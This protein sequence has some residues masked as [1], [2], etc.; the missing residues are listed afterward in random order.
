[1]RA[2]MLAFAFSAVMYSAAAFV[3]PEAVPLHRRQAPGTPQYECHADCGGVIVDARTPGYCDSA[4]F[5]TTL[6]ACLDCALQYDIW[7]YY[8]E[9]VAEAAEGCGLDATPVPANATAATTGTSSS[10]TASGSETASSSAA[11]DTSAGSSSGAS[12]TSASPSTA[13]PSSS[14][15]ATAAAS[16]AAASATSDSAGSRALWT[17]GLAMIP[18]AAAM[19]DFV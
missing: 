10:A 7:Q 8:G 12:E 2:C 4:N 3:Y 18:L 6:D 5:T 15:T 17:G 19:A 16:G 9:S 1:M 13:A 11:S 14:E